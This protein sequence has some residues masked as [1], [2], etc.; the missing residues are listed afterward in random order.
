METL[1]YRHLYHAEIRG[2]GL[3]LVHRIMRMFRKARPQSVTLDWHYKE[4]DRDGTFVFISGV[5]GGKP[6][7]GLSYIPP[8][9]PPVKSRHV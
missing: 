3:G 9:H 5:R 6:L 1:P 8:E 2:H 7:S 4:I